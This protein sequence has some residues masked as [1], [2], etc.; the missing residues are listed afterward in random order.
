MNEATPLLEV[1]DIVKTFHVRRSEIRALSGVSLSIQPASLW[2][3]SVRADP[4]RARSHV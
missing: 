3:S 4:G 2:A 1:H